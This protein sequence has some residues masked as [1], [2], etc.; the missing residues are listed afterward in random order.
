[1]GTWRSAA[2]DDTAWRCP[3]GL[4]KSARAAEQDRA[5]GSRELRLVATSDGRAAASVALRRKRDGRRIY[6]YLRWSDSGRTVELYIGEV[7]QPT[8]AENLARAWRLAIEQ[9]ATDSPATD[10]P[11]AASWASSPAVRAVMRANRGRDTRPELSVRAAVHA[12]GLRYRVGI[13]PLPGIRRTADLVFPKAK[14]AVFVD[15]CF[16][17]GCPEHHRPAKQNAEFWRAKI[18]G[19]AARDADT[20]KRLTDAGWQ[21]IRIWEHEDAAEAAAAITEVVRQCGR[22]SQPEPRC[23]ELLRSTERT[24]QSALPHE[25]AES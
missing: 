8:R 10:S 18:E 23:R 11:K 13:S 15:G 5:A 24:H 22:G 9:T 17:H 4:T 6:A 19:N 21:V 25:A 7:D 3:P 16:W 14:V 2:P 1:M 12:Q 20:N